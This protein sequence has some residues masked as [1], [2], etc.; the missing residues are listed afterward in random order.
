MDQCEATEGIGE[1]F[2]RELRYLIGGKLFSFV[3]A[4]EDY[5][6][7]RVRM[8]PHRSEDVNIELF[9]VTDRYSYLSS[10]AVTHK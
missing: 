10:S 2:G 1:Q 4:A 5:C 9:R 6:F 8:A 3:H 7:E